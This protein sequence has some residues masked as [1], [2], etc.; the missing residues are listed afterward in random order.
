MSE[1]ATTEYYDFEKV[2]PNKP[3]KYL[4]VENNW[5]A[6]NLKGEP[7]YRFNINIFYWT[8][9]NWVDSRGHGIISPDQ[10]GNIPKPKKALKI[11]TESVNF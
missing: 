2:K 5:R 8:G 4:W 10:W 7:I 3:G 1:I 9:N 6:V 11:A